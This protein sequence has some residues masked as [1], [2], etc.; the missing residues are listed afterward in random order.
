MKNALFSALT[1]V[2]LALAWPTYGFPLLLFFGFVPLLLVEFDLRQKKV[3]R[4]G[5]KVFGL[6][7]LGFFIWNL[8]TTYWI[9]YST[10]EGAAFALL[11]NT[12]LMSLVFL[13]YHHTARR[14]NFTASGVFLASLWM[15]FE[16]LHLHWDFSWP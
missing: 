5:W 11:V 8:I 6:A 12:L 1:G 15:C 7:Y 13:I 3:K 10:P 2:L 14:I 4:L 9:Y 16:Y